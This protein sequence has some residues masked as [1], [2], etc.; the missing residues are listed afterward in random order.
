MDIDKPE[1]YKCDECHAIIDPHN[2]DSRWSTVREEYICWGCYESEQGHSSTLVV[3][4]PSEES[5]R[6]VYVNDYEIITEYGDN[7]TDLKVKREW[8]TANYY[9]GYYETTIEG[10]DDV[11]EGW[12]TG[13]W[14]DSTARRKQTFNEWA[15]ELTSGELVPPCPVAIAI[16]PTSNVFST[17]ITVLVHKNNVEKFREWLS[18]DYEE[19]T[20]AL[21]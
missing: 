9:R 10:W 1:E 13:G 3:I 4:D 19:L 11:L 7:Y 17:A 20:E 14:D 2:D 21:S 5:P 18:D 15:E 8:H 16:D 6:K 12:T